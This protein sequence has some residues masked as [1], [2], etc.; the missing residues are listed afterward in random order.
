LAP[1]GLEVCFILKVAVSYGGAASGR[2]RS[3]ASCRRLPR[4]C[5]RCCRASSRCVSGKKHLS[6]AKLHP[7][8]VLRPRTR[9]EYPTPAQLQVRLF[10]ARQHL[11]RP[12]LTSAMPPRHRFGQQTPRFK[13]ICMM[14]A[15][16]ASTPPGTRERI[17]ARARACVVPGWSESL[18]DA[19]GIACAV[20]VR[21]R[22][23]WERACLYYTVLRPAGIG[24]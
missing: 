17:A 9:A 12:I 23:M 18:L 16:G 20:R 6:R 14:G 21:S 19:A 15:G 7:S 10:G 22:S 2:S 11:R 3:V 13:W 4:C 24:I 5:P 1:R 8:G